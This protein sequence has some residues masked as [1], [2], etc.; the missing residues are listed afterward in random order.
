[1]WHPLGFECLLE[2]NAQS[3]Q[4][5]V[6]EA[7]WPRNIAERVW[8]EMTGSVDKISAEA[9]DAAR[10]RASIELALPYNV[11]DYLLTKY[12]RQRH[13]I[14]SFP[15]PLVL[16]VADTALMSTRA[17]A[18]GVPSTGHPGTALVSLIGATEWTGDLMKCVSAPWLPRQ[19]IEAYRASLAEAPDLTTVL[20][21]RG[22]ASPVNVVESLVT[23][24]VVLPLLDLR[25][26]YGHE[27]FNDEREYMEHL[28]EFPQPPFIITPGGI[29]PSAE[30]ND[31]ILQ[32]WF[33]YSM[34]RSVMAQVTA[35]SS[36][37]YCP[38]AY[39][40]TPA[41]ELVEFAHSGSCRDHIRKRN[42]M[43]WS[44]GH[45]SKLPDCV[46]S[47]MMGALGFGR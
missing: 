38:R 46:F 17:P 9:I 11:V 36:V 13:A 40:S 27:V 21:R 29:I 10:A 14:R 25:L 4:R 7:L 19:S 1:V 12:L 18:L 6:L 22:F 32:K 45:L 43:A 41:I 3:L 23:H 42:C 44:T 8:N 33:E 37:V 31:V 15:R 30:I 2:G 47:A 16:K 39:A 35:D 26:K 34:M 28:A 5:D 24:N 20:S